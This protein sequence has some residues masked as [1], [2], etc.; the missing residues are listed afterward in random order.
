MAAC[1]KEHGLAKALRHIGLFERSIFILASLRDP[2]Q[3]SMSADGIKLGLNKGEARNTLA[4]GVFMHRLG[5][6]SDCGLESMVAVPIPGPPPRMR[7]R[8]A[9]IRLAITGRT[10]QPGQC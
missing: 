3:H 5:E 10:G 9:N 8:L 4:G 2:A 1:C 7:T 6:I